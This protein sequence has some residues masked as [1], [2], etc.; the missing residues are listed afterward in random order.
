MM[1]S[2]SDI[3]ITIFSGICLGKN[4][5]CMSLCN[6]DILSYLK[7]VNVLQHYS[8]IIQK[9]DICEYKS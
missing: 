3:N 7:K 1:N 4:F 9:H 6:I 2:I 5:T 8:C